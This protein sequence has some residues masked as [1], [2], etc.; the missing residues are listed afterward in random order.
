[1]SFIGLALYWA[2]QLFLFAMIIRFISDLIMSVNRGWRPN[3]ILLPV[4]DIAYTLT[5]PPLAFLRRFIK[6]IRFGGLAIDLA[7]TVLFFAVLFGQN[8]ATR[9]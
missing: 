5:D 6:P 4:F 7:W 2:L 8:F 9:L 3:S 1:M